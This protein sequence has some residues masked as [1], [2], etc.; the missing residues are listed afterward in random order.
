[1]VG[2]AAAADDRN[3]RQLFIR[4]DR[5]RDAS[6]FLYLQAQGDVREGFR[7]LLVDGAV[8]VLVNRPPDLARQSLYFGC[9]Q[10]AVLVRVERQKLLGI[11]RLAIRA[12]LGQRADLLRRNDAV[13]VGVVF[14][15]EALD[16][17]LVVVFQPLA[18]LG[19]DGMPAVATL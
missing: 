17:R 4:A 3:E 1:N 18:F 6:A 5:R 15:Q 9:G 7:F 8:A 11:G 16:T 2:N 19:A 10:D 12:S 14:A 13:L